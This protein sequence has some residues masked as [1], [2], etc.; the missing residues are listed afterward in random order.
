MQPAYFGASRT[1]LLGLYHPPTGAR[2]RDHGVLLCQPAPQE[3]MRCHWALRKLAVLLAREGF[4][5]LRFDWF[6]SGDSAG[7]TD[8]GRP[9][10]WRLDVAAALEELRDVSGVRR[11]SLVGFR[12]GAALAAQAP[13]KL[14]D[15][16]LWEPV[17]S[18]REHVSELLEQH[19]LRFHHCLH[20]PRV[21][22]E[23]MGLPFPQALRDEIEAI[24]LRAPLLCRA[25]R[26][27]VLACEERASYLRL[28]EE[29]RAAA[30]AG[31][32][33]VEWRHVTEEAQGEDDAFLMSN[34]AQQAIAALLAGREATS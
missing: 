20:P 14:R 25:E 13:L 4:H 32:P 8:A 21:P 23:L 6:G 9:S 12:L 26:V 24:E 28:V 5:V 1:R 30:A 7:A 17:V 2:A 11:A 22:D 16:V 27:V 15:L 19:V 34:R 10:Q 29:L 3:Y 18:G 31:G 33:A